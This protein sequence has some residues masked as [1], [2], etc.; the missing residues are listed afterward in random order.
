MRRACLVAAALVLL[1]ISAAGCGK[2]GPLKPPE[3]RGPTSPKE[4]T[5]RQ[6][7]DVVEISFLAPAPRGSNPSQQPILAELVRVAYGPGLHPP[8][9]PDAFRRTGAVVAQIEGDPLGSGSRLRFRDPSWRDLSGNGVD[10]T[11]RYGVRVRDRR[12]RP[13]PLVVAPDLVPVAPPPVPFGL[14][15]E[16][17]ADGI[18]LRWDPPETGGSTK[19]NVYRAE[20]G[21]PFGE[22]PLNREALASAEYLDADVTLGKSYRY[23]VRSALFEGPPFR[24]SAS[25][26]EV[27]VLAEDRFPPAP[28]SGLVAVQEGQAIR[29]FWNP[30]QE[31][32]LAGYRVF[33]RTEPGEWLTIGRNLGVEPLLLDP[34]VRPGTKVH[35]RV[36][37]VDRAGNESRPSEAVEVDVVEDTGTAKESGRRGPP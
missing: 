28:P 23:V 29:L 21:D 2:K 16:A 35:Y 18:R 15:A 4:V 36:I 9:D 13:S 24:E 10:W 27:D 1:A 32:D 7:G 22:R 17:T 34:E 5:A 26:P 31:R 20:R 8:Q 25:S 30:N 37:A 11:L 3:P 6:T 12:G 14:A 33:R 19:Y